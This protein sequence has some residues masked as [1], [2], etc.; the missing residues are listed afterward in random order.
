MTEWELDALI[1]GHSKRKRDSWE[2]CRFLAY[3]TACSMGAKIKSPT[4][5]ISFPWE[6]EETEEEIVSNKPSKEMIKQMAKEFENELKNN[7]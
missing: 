3:V 2:Q 6:K 4:D 1:L 5:L 7:K